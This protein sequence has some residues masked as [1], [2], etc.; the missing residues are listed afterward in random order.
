MATAL[1]QEPDLGY[2]Q[3]LG[4]GTTAA[5]LGYDDRGYGPTPTS[6]DRGYD[7][8]LGYENEEPRAVHEGPQKPRQ[9]A[10]RRCSVTKYSL[11]ASAQV[12]SQDFAQPDSQQPPIAGH[13]EQAEISVEFTSTPDSSESENNRLECS[14]VDGSSSEEAQKNKS[15]RGKAFGRIRRALSSA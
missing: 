4:Y 9:Q 5:D 8:E 14:S 11:E 7:D 13:P 10:R 2:G 12:Q 6:E 3:D 15:R 1:V